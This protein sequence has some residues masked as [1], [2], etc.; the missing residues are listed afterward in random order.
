MA[1]TKLFRNENGQSITVAMAVWYIKDSG[2]WRETTKP[3]MEV[4]EVQMPVR[5]DVMPVTF[6]VQWPVPED[7]EDG[8]YYA[9]LYPVGWEGEVW[10]GTG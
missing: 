1:R 8:D 7:G 6:G 2:A 4:M 10:S 5:A 9:L 3:E